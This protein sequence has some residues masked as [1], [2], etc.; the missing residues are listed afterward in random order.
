MEDLRIVIQ[1]ILNRNRRVEAE[2]AWEVSAARRTSI[3]V[4]TYG[5]ATIFLW[6]IRIPFFYLQALVP[7]L[8]YF[9]STLSLPWIKR[10]WMKN[11]ESKR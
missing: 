3:L 9:L 6:S 11:H 10:R 8:G 2:K 1:D 4:L 7:T 5:I